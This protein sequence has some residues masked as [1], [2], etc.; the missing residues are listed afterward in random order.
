ML[1]AQVK[2]PDARLPLL[3][4]IA[5]LA[6]GAVIFLGVHRGHGRGAPEGGSHHVVA[7]P[8]QP[9]HAGAAN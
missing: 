6:G 1:R 5:A 3:V 9:A 8:A 4:L 2:P 7:A